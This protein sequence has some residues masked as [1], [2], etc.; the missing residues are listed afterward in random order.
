MKG[1]IF[2]EFLDFVAAAHGDDMVDDIIDDCRL[3]NGGAY[4]SVGTYDHA[5]MQALIAALAQRT[6]APAPEILGR[7]GR[8][9]F[10]RFVELFPAL[11][12]AF[13]F[14]IS[15]RASRATS[16]LRFISSTLMRNFLRLKHIFATAHALRS[17]IGA[18]GRSRLWRRV[19]SSGL[20]ITSA[21]PSASIND[22][23][24]MVAAVLC[25][26]SF[27]ICNERSCFGDLRR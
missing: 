15:S 24:R 18:V 8:H 22:D 6:R 12:T 26:L 2:T 1:L 20:Q 13:V 17:T 3:P 5:E 7:Y 23:M 4:T 9:L 27:G 25:A 14:L 11:K 16:T 10:H 19:S 21:S